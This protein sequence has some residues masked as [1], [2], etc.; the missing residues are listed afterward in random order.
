M[1]L[2]DELSGINRKRDDKEIERIPKIF[3][4]CDDFI[5]VYNYHFYDRLLPV[6]IK[7]QAISAKDLIDL[8]AFVQ[9]YGHDKLLLWDVI[10]EGCEENLSHKICCNAKVSYTDDDV[11]KLLQSPINYMKGDNVMKDLKDYYT[12][13]QALT[14]G[15][16]KFE[17]EPEEE[18]ALIEKYQDELYHKFVP[19]INTAQLKTLW[20]EAELK[21]QIELM[22]YYYF[23]NKF[24]T[25][26]ARDAVLKQNNWPKMV[27]LKENVLSQSCNVLTNLELLC[28][29]VCMSY[30]N[31]K[32]TLSDIVGLIKMKEDLKDVVPIIRKYKIL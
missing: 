25:Q 29:M 30:E 12:K 7:N 18:R 26:H 2:F 24:I 5:L 17:E 23:L 10:V 28:D 15:I 16:R 4:G 22:C 20:E 6:A 31:T 1:G 21:N 11:V 14:L 8:W 19:S 3:F 27:E 9:N 32:W 13:E